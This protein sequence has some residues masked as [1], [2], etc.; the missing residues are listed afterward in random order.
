MKQ[1]LELPARNSNGAV[2]LW[3]ELDMSQHSSIIP[4]KLISTSISCIKRLEIPCI[5]PTRYHVYYLAQLTNIGSLPMTMKR[6]NS[7]RRSVGEFLKPNNSFFPAPDVD[8]DL[9]LVAVVHF[10]ILPPRSPFDG[11]LKTTQR[12]LVVPSL[13]RGQMGE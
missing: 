4:C 1:P 10:G 9:E 11:A 2:F 8:F 13:L 3:L 6:T 12:C 7:A 5:A